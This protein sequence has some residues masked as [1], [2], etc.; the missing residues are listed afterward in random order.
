MHIPTVLRS[1]HHLHATLASVG[2]LFHDTA[3]RAPFTVNAR[4]ANDLARQLDPPTNKPRSVPRGW[5]ETDP[6]ENPL[7]APRDILLR[8]PVPLPEPLRPLLE[9]P[10]GQAAAA[11]RAALRATIG[12]DDRNVDSMHV[13]PSWTKDKPAPTRLARSQA[14]ERHRPV[15]APGPGA[16]TGPGR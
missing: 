3:R 14:T 11:S 6:T 5:P 1:L 16:V 4:A 7:I 8:R 13:P 15:P 12:A 10:S 2:E 9:R